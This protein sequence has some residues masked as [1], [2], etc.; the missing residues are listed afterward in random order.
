MKLVKLAS[1]ATLVLASQAFAQGGATEAVEAKV[2]FVSPLTAAETAPLNF[3]VLTTDWKTVGGDIVVTADAT[4][5]ADASI[6][7]YSDDRLVTTGKV[8]FSGWTTGTI[9]SSQ[10]AGI[11]ITADSSV[12]LDNAAG[13]NAANNYFDTSLQCLT[14]CGSHTKTYLSS[15]PTIDVVIGGTLSH[16]TGIAGLKADTYVGSFDVSAAYE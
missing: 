1:L 15:N 8:T 3:G 14:G 4:R 5:A 12:V 11:V 7:V 2:E 13:D 9:G 10:L 16:G 6:E